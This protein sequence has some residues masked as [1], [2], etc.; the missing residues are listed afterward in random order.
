MALSKFLIYK[1]PNYNLNLV[2]KR[3]LKISKSD[4]YAKSG[5]SLALQCYPSFVGRGFS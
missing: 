3:R 1:T 2:G 4:I 5:T